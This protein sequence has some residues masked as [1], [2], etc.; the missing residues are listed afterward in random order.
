M[1][2][3]RRR[4]AIPPSESVSMNLNTAD[5]PPRLSGNETRRLLEL[6]ELIKVES[7]LLPRALQQELLEILER[8]RPRGDVPVA[9]PEMSRGELIRAIRWRVGT[10]PLAGAAAAAE[11]VAQ[12]RPK[13]GRAK[14]ASTPP[15]PQPPNTRG[16]GP[17]S[18]RGEDQR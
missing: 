16:R 9:V 4:V 7:L 14:A 5:K 1:G 18:I 15:A 11:F 6:R 13:R 2:E 12:H 8:A 10:V 17:R 3:H